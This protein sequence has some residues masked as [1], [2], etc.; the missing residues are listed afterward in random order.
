MLSLSVKENHYLKKT[1]TPVVKFDT[2][3]GFFE[4]WHIPE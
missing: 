4:C 2:E 1:A 3:A